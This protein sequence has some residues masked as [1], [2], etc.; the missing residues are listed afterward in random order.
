HGYLR[1]KPATLEVM[2]E[3]QVLGIEMRGGRAVGVTVRRGGERKTLSAR[4]GVVLSA[5]ALNTPRLLMLSGIGPGDE[6]RAHGIEVVA[7]LPGVG[8]NLQEHP[9][10]HL[11]NTVSAHTLND[12]S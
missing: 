8:R 10:C 5:G 2:T 11:V 6:L 1:N 9:G 3:A 4:R 12:E 7:D